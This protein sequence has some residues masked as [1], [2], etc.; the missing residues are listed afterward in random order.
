MNNDVHCT[1]ILMMLSQSFFK[2]SPLK[3]EVGFTA[4][5]TINNSSDPSS[6][7]QKQFLTFSISSHPI[8]KERQV[9]FGMILSCLD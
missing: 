2:L 3:N 6:S 5:T 4:N 7:N 9:F 1:K 8:W